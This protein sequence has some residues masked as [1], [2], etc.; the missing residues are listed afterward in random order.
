[1]FVGRSSAV[2]CCLGTRRGGLAGRP[3]GRR[4]QV[5]AD[6]AVEI[7][8]DVKILTRTVPTI[9]HTAGRDPPPIFPQRSRDLSMMCPYSAAAAPDLTTACPFFAKC[10]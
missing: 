6:G 10:F 5:D 4:D 9:R 7:D 3:V 2:R 8:R 1:M